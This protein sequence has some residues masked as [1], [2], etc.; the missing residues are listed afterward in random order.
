MVGEYHAKDY[1]KHDGLTAFG[2]DVIKEMNGLGMIVDISHVSDG[3]VDDVLE[4]STAPVMASHSSCR[5]LTDMPRNLTDDQIKRIAAK[6]GVVMI[7]IGGF[8]I[9][10]KTWD[11]LVAT[12]RKLAPDIAKAQKDAGKDMAKF[13]GA[14]FAMYGKELAN[15]PKASLA[16]VA[17]HIEHVIKVG[18][19]DA[20]GLG[21]DFDGIPNPPTGFEDYSKLPDLVKEL[22]R[23]G[24]SDAEVRKILGE[25][26]LA[27]FARVEKSKR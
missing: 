18:G 6:G 21:T 7:N 25:N 19:I 23:R 11:A 9:Q 14:V 26:F 2:K 1:I 12:K 10:Q 4:V 16:D 3:T 15:A 20:V 17:D 22:L 8:L 13:Y 5:A 27:F 24:H